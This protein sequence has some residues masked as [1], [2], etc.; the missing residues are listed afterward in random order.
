[1]LLVPLITLLCP[2]GCQPCMASAFH[3]LDSADGVSDRVSTSAVTPSQSPTLVSTMNCWISAPS[4][5]HAGQSC[6]QPQPGAASLPPSLPGL[7]SFALC[8]VFRSDL[9]MLISL[10]STSAR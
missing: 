9:Q 3:G 7:Q 2:G 4:M 10:L 1:M 8:F 5:L 6:P